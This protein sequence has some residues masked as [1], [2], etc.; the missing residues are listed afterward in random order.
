MEQQAVEL[1]Q[2]GDSDLRLSVIG[3]GC[4]SFGGGSYWG[5]TDQKVADTVVSRAVE[6]GVNYFDTAEAY[7]DGQS[8]LSLGKAIKNVSRDKV[9]IGSKISP[10]NA[11]PDKILAHCEASLRRL[12]T[13][14]ID[15]YMLHWPPNPLSLRNFTDDERLITSP[16][17][18]EDIVAGMQKLR[19]QG[20][21][22]Y[23]SVSNFGVPWMDRMSALGEKPVVNQLPYNL[24]SR[25]IEYEVVPYCREHGI[26]IIGYS[27][28]LQG[29]LAGLYEAIE[30][31]PDL[32]RR[33]RHFN[34]TRTPLSR[35]GEEGAEV[36]TQRALDGIRA[37]ARETGKS[38]AALAVSWAIRD[39]A[40]TCVIA[41]MRTVEKVDENVQAALQPLPEEVVQ[42]LDV[43]TRPLM[44][45]LGN[46]V[47]MWESAEN[48]RTV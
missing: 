28:L 18:L 33:T 42:Q 8:E 13:D 17:L 3:M 37:I 46:H 38:M 43:V 2:A 30:D 24:L 6:A 44:E 16:P 10:T 21:I 36:E 26:G 47:D 29:I 4:W 40:I 27:V 41:G 25:A 12:D 39:P 9:I 7:N 19:D 48:D 5:P 35:H 31:I 20:K 45:K 15:V 32:Q 11:Y 23:P 1:R 34:S 14:Y 22:R